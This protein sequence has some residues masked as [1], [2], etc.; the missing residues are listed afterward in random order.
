VTTIVIR[1]TPLEIVWQNAH[2]EARFP[3]FVEIAAL[4]LD[5]CC[6][7]DEVADRY[8]WGDATGAWDEYASNRWLLGLDDD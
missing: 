7:L 2:T 4:D 3:D 1:R 5:P 6:R 8:G